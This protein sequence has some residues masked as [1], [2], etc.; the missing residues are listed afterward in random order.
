M[1]SYKVAKSG[2]KRVIVTLEIPE[3]AITNMNRS[4]I[5]VRQTAKY[6]ANKVKVISIEDEE[7]N[8]YK[9]ARPCF[10]DRDILYEVPKMVVCEDFD[11]TLENVC[12]SGI[13]FFL[14]RKVAEQYGLEE[15]K[16]G[17]LTQYYDN[18]GKF[19]EQ[20]YVNGLK[21]GLFQLWEES[22]QLVATNIYVK[23]L[24]H[25]PFICFWSDGTVKQTG[26]Y[27]NNKFNGN[28]KEYYSNGVLAI[29]KIYK[30]GVEN[31]NLRKKYLP[32]GKRWTLWKDIEYTF[33]HNNPALL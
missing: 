17:T 28:Y 7:G 20:S 5:A 15:I 26:T 19:I 4:T 22:G 6:R 31:K 13:H 3:D 12:S 25:G 24:S 9:I 1:I 14:D 10:F 2:E 29:E 18:G 32:N 8:M 11:M 21:D 23:G 27:N 16:N 30:D 33:I